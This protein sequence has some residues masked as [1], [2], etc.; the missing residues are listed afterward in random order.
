MK[1]TRLLLLVLGT[2]L[3]ASVVLVSLDLGVMSVL[4]TISLVV[5]LLALL[6]WG[7]WRL[8]NAFLWKV[9][10]RLAFSYFL[11][12][13]LPIPLVLMVL[14]A[15]VYIQSGF[16]LGHLY[17]DAVEAVQAEMDADTRLALEWA[18]GVAPGR[19]AARFDGD[20][21]LPSVLGTTDG[22]ADGLADGAA[23]EPHRELETGSVAYALYR[24]GR[25]VAGD[26]RLPEAWPAW[27]QEL[28]AAAAAARATR[29]APAP[30]E[31][32]AD[33]AGTDGTGD[34]A[35][36][37]DEDAAGTQAG[38][39]A[40][41]E[42][43]TEAQTEAETG[44]DPEPGGDPEFSSD[45]LQPLTDPPIFFSAGN[46]QPTL[47]SAAGDASLGVASVYVGDLA[48]ELTERSDVWVRLFG[49]DSGEGAEGRVDVQVMGRNMA[50]KTDPSRSPEAAEAYFAA[51]G[52][53]TDGANAFQRWWDRPFLWWGEVRG[54][55]H[56]LADG[57]RVVDRFGVGLN[58]PPRT[59]DRN[60][61]SLTAE[62]DVSVW[63]A[64]V[65]FAFLLFD[66]Y[67]VAALMASIMI[68]A[69]SR[70]VNRL[71]KA[72][73]AVRSGDFS[74]RIPVRRTDQVGQLQRSFNTMAENL[75][76]L[77]A[78][79]TQKELLEKELSIARDLQK[80]L[81]PRDLPH[82]EGIEFASLFEPSAAIGGDYF[83]VLRLGE[84]RL[85][86]V[87]ADVSGHGLPTGLRMAM[88][89]SALTILVAE[90]RPV[91]EIL[92]KLDAVVRLEGEER[93]FVTATVA[94]LDFRS[95]RL[96]ITN[97]GHPPTY[98]L[99]RGEVREILLPGQPLGGISHRWGK[100]AL[101]LEAGDVLVWLSDGLIEASD[102]DDETFGYDGVESA[103][104]EIAVRAEATG[105]DLSAAAVRDHLVAAVA[106]HTGSRSA[107]DDRTLVALRFTKAGAER[108][109]SARADE[110]PTTA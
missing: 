72:T 101:D 9:G 95:G 80:S 18:D 96:E 55:L 75:E 51:R 76:E 99:R 82:G 103:L 42:A 60:L 24:D 69:L 7:A 5:S 56:A 17:H 22:G 77:V 81:V 62:L 86:V 71:S 78:T 94:L 6:L 11:V 67:L 12:G 83:D 38:T 91:E 40:Q 1:N 4:A 110:E 100:E 88:L 106:E 31:A 52:G 87:V 34:E 108:S 27:I 107:E 19:A 3:V 109:S 36:A 44:G 63:S 98:L 25:R 37:G 32:S 29:N 16:I 10:R 68:Y 79:A 65:V 23:V 21:A 73:D 85:A 13:V 105:A 26:P 8:Y 54:P 90:E 28:P 20:P 59:L 58:A 97:A 89:K 84:D 53:S 41:N 46:G 33:D 93:Y 57:E 35:A 104:E 61:F 102:E 74:V 48:Q 39:Q 30:D 70:A 49:P 15:V 47:A 45:E 66:V 92:A 64:L 2:V 14:A 43:Q 50:L